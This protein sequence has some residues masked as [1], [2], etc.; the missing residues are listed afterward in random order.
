[1]DE[2]E[3]NDA[4]A[5]VMA[6]SKLEMPFSNFE[7]TVMQQIAEEVTRKKSISKQ[8][9]LSQ[10]FFVLGSV[11]GFIIAMLLS[12]IEAPVFGIDQNIIALTFQILFATLFFTQIERFFKI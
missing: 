1:M 2:L 11:F 5:E 7:D 10:F 9:R 12:Q 3:K 6:K 4:F 8:L